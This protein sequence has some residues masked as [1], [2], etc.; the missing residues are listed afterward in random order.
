MSDR[1]FSTHLADVSYENGILFTRY[2]GITASLEEIKAFVEQIKKNFG[3]LLPL[4][5]ISNITKQKSPKKEVRDYLASPEVAKLITAGAIIANSTLSKIAGN[6]FLV[7]NQPIRPTQIF[8]DEASALAW[9][10]QFK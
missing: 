5:M 10:Q 4:P 3:N 7:F 1:I 8:T 6:L 9:L 2:K